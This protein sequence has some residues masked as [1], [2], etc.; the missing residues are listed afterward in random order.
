MATDAKKALRKSMKSRLST[1]GEEDVTRQSR[2]AQQLILDLPQYK[3]ARRIS[4]YLAMPN[5]EAQTDLIV[6][7][8]FKAGKEI[9]VPHI[10]RP[11][12]REGETKKRSTIEMLLLASP[13]EYQGLQRDSWG[14]PS[15]STDGLDKRENAM[16]GKGLGAAGD[17]DAEGSLDLVVVPG[18]A[19]DT[20]MNRLGHGA[21]FYDEYLTRYSRIK[22]RRPFLGKLL[23]VSA[24]TS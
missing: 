17:G 5:A 16:G 2:A 4:V 11:K 22:E 10:H 15:L 13:Q 12:A 19:F 6:H 7:D 23:L 18:V 14:I 8:A 21:G 1:L 20:K 9:F 3:D 24:S